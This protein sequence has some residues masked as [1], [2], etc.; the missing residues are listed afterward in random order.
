MKKV[1]FRQIEDANNSF[2]YIIYPET[3]TDKNEVNFECFK[4]NEKILETWEYMDALM[5]YTSP[6]SEQNLS[7]C[8]KLFN[9]DEIEIVFPCDINI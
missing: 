6:I 5:Y 3:L 1:I 2:I 8:K 7:I 9:P 4:N